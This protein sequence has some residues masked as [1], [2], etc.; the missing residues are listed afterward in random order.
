[1]GDSAVRR[2]SLAVTALTCEEMLP[3][4][5]CSARLGDVSLGAVVARCRCSGSDGAEAV[6][7]ALLRVNP[8]TLALT[9]GAGEAVL[10]VMKVLKGEGALTVG[11]PT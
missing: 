10:V 4:L 8:V 11:T 1:M 6:A 2:G 9:A 7:D 3:L 5:L